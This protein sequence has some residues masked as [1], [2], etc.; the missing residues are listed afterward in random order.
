[1]NGAQLITRGMC[2]FLAMMILAACSSATPSPT[3]APPPTWTPIHPTAVPVEGITLNPAKRAGARMAYDTKTD[4]AILFGG[5]EERPCWDDCPLIAET[6]IY[7]AKDNA[8]IQVS[9]ETSPDPRVDTAM[10]YDAE[11]DQTILYA[12]FISNEKYSPQDTWAFD[13]KTLTWTKMKT[14]GPPDRY[15]HSMV[16]D[17]E[18]DRM[19]V[20]GGWSFAENAGTNDTWAYDYN[21]DTWTEVQTALK[22]PGRNF[23]AMTYD[24]KAD[25]VIL[26]GGDTGGVNDNSVWA[27]DY[28]SQTWEERKPAGA[29]P[30]SRWLHE[31][32]YD[33]EADRTI[34]YGGYTGSGALAPNYTLNN[35]ETWAYDYNQNTWTQLN[36]G[37]N[38]GALSEF[39][40]VYLGA[41]D[42][43]LLF[44]GIMTDGNIS[45]KSWLY[46]FNTNSW[47]GV[48]P[49]NQ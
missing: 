17:S 19:I 16:Y 9:P 32:S 26:F 25:R 22:P 38:P 13:M 35:A 12:G 20:F 24:S 21:S 33:S 27:F 47:S 2:L 39:A 41:T 3:P 43:V 23:Q 46:D 1:M 45:D 11:S 15:G 7:E 10:A 48:R 29:A 37:V 44:G 40:Q 4:R 42:R 49:E 8:W 5:S 6:L 28:N 34:L 36:P 18:S 31:M 30:S 14:E